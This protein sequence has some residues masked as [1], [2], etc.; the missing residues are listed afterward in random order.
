MNKPVQAGEKIDWPLYIH[1]R[2]NIDPNQTV[3]EV[4]RK[5]LDVGIDYAAAV[6][7]HHN[8]VGLISLKMV[9]AAL[10][11]RFGQ[12]L[13]ANK[14]LGE[15]CIP[16]VIL[17]SPRNGAP[18]VQ[19]TLVIPM[20]QVAVLNPTTSFFAAQ[21][22]LQGRPVERSFDDVIMVSETG[23]FQGMISMSNF[24]KLQMDILRWHEIEL[25]E[26]NQQLKEAKELAEA[27]DRAKSE[28]LAIMSHEI[29]T[30]MNGVI[31]MTSILA[32]T[33]LNDLQRDCIST[34]QTS[35]ES[36]L[37]VIN[38]IL[39]FSK[40]ESGRMQLESEVFHLP[41]CVEEALDLFAAQIRM[42]KLEAVYLVSPD[43]PAGL[44]GDAM[45]LRQILVNLIGNAIKFT[46]EGEIKIEAQLQSQDEQGCHL[47]FSVSDTGIGIKK[48]GISKLFGAFQQV[49]TSTTRRYGG[50]GLGLVISKRLAGFMN[51]TMW[52]ESTP[53][54]GSTFYF[55]VVM[56]AA[57][58]SATYLHAVPGPGLLKSC[59]ALIVDDNATNR[60]ILERQLKI[61]GINTLSAASGAEA[62]ERFTEHCFDTVLLDLQM[63]EMD[64]IAL[65]RQL[66]RQS[67]V[68]LILLSSSGELLVGE[69]GALFQFQVPKPI[70]HS[71]LFN[72]L[73][74][75]TGVAS[76]LP[77]KVW[78]KSSMRAWEAPFPCA[79]SLP[80]IIR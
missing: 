67:S 27:A 80:K 63:P 26:R 72:A 33:E 9:S 36:L 69:E 37:A 57:P 28:F 47:L 44:M 32:D 78:K 11:A 64:G 45:R 40:I 17:G 16:S 46:T 5:M 68:P 52:V 22:T 70:R 71:Q 75:I 61:W 4:H 10:S 43:I 34:I 13:F 38:D 51:G 66:R 23:K 62:L 15:T 54:V 18:D 59:S 79:S 30:P 8:L 2:S 42:K 56:Q 77:A 53:G 3:A 25:R 65:A 55:T 1:H 35:G 49:D 58:P 14:L 7:D 24:M 60:R 20:E 76:T 73:L 48:E 41:Q 50:T 12:A 39:D 74:K 6:D 21:A 31:G 19:L 29:R